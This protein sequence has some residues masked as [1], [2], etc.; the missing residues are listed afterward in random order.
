MGIIRESDV[1]QKLDALKNYSVAADPAT[2]SL[3]APVYAAV[4]TY[5]NSDNTQLAAALEDV[6]KYM[7]ND[8]SR[9]TTVY[10]NEFPMG[11]ATN[12]PAGYEDITECFYGFTQLLAITESSFFDAFV[13]GVPEGAAGEGGAI[14]EI[15]LSNPYLDKWTAE[16]TAAVDGDLQK[17]I[18]L[19]EWCKNSGGSCDLICL[20][21]NR[22]RILSQKTVKEKAE[23]IYVD[24][25]LNEVI[26]QKNLSVYI[27]TY[28][29]G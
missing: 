20:L 21:E 10:E 29:K 9:R 2:E 27:P 8:I 19:A 23:I 24:K 16:I 17:I 22:G 14:T 4:S 1:L 6:V 15:P 13:Y 3:F 5:F 7:Y 26:Q 12:Y 28:L 11:L 18:A 25:K